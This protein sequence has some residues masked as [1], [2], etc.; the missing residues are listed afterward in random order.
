MS[1]S[2]MVPSPL[3][4]ARVLPYGLNA[5]ELTG[6]TGPRSTATGEEGTQLVAKPQNQTPVAL[7]A[8]RVVPS[9]LNATELTRPV[10]LVRRLPPGRWVATSH[11]RTLASVVAV[12]RVLVSG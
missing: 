3:P 2:R 6:P 12:A 11:S 9:G 8:T 10:G 1:H 4:V 7:P 5:T